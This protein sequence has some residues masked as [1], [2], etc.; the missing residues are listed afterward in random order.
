MEAGLVLVSPLCRAFQTAIVALSGHPTV[1]ESGMKLLRTIRE[2]KKS[3]AGVDCKADKLGEDISAR[4]RAEL[5]KIV[6]EEQVN[7]MMPDEL[8]AKLNYNDTRSKW[9]TENRL[10]LTK[11]RSKPSISSVS[12][13]ISYCCPC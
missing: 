13:V 11:H 4:V 1:R 5:A 7:A 9:W 6:G 2:I 12:S 8:M 10:T 3:R